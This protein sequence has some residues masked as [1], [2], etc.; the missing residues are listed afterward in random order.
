MS[1]TMGQMGFKLTEER[2][3]WHRGCI[4]VVGHPNGA[5]FRFWRVRHRP[6]G[7]LR[8]YTHYF[9]SPEAAARAALETWGDK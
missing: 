6:N 4:A 3:E 8:T 9:D 2:N 7:W 5:D 1:E